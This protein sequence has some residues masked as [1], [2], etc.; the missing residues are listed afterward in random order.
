MT[1]RLSFCVQAATNLSQRDLDV[2]TDG[3][4]RYVKQGFD[5]KNAETMAVADA[6]A[7][8]RAERGELVDALMAQQK[9]LVG[10]VT[11]AELM[12]PSEQ[13]TQ[14]DAKL[15][16]KRMP[17]TVEVS[18]RGESAV[19]KVGSKVVGKAYAWNDS[20][21]DFVIM[22]TE[23][24]EKYRRRG[25]ASAM[26][27]AIEDATG[28]Q[29]TPAVS[30]S[31]DAFEMWKKFRPE[32]VAK[33]LRHWKDQLIGARVEH[34]GNAGKIIKANGGTATMELDK[35][36]ENGGTQSVILRKDLNAAL[37]AGGS[38]TIDALDGEVRQSAKRDGYITSDEIT[39]MYQGGWESLQKDPEYI[40][41]LSAM[42]AA[43]DAASE[44]W[45]EVRQKAKEILLS[46]KAFA[47]VA[48]K[49]EERTILNLASVYMDEADALVPEPKPSI[50]DTQAAMNAYT[51]RYFSDVVGIPEPREFAEQANQER[52][53]YNTPKFK[54]W[55]KDS[56]AVDSN[57][58]PLVAFHVT[59]HDFVEFNINAGGNADKKSHAAYSG[60]LGSWFTAPSLRPESYDIGNAESA[61]DHFIQDADGQSKPGA[62]TM[63]VHLSIQ[64]PMEYDDFESMLEDRDSFPSIAKYKADLVKQGYD[65]IVIRNSDTDG[66]VDRDDWVAF[67]PTQIKSALGNSG[68]FSPTD[69][70]INRS[71]S[72][73]PGFDRF[74]GD[75]PIIELGQKHNF[76]SGEPVVVEVLHGTTNAD[77]TEF[78]RDLAGVDGDW[79]AGFYA[80]NS[81][82]DVALNYANNDAQD[83]TNKIERVA[84]SIE[85]E[86]E[87]SGEFEDQDEIRAEAMRRAKEKITQGSPNTL[88]LFMRLR[89]PVVIGPGGTVLDYDEAYDEEADEYSEPTGKLVEFID[90]LRENASDF[91]MPSGEIETAIADLFADSVD[92]ITVEKAK[93]IL[94]VSMMAAM[95][96]DGNNATAEVIRRSLADIGFDGII[97][98]TVAKKFKMKG[99]DKDSIHFIAFNPNQLKSAT[100]NNG[101]FSEKN[102]ITQ[103]VARP[104]FYSQLQ[105]AIEGVPE[106]LSTQAGAQW[107]LWLDANA[108]KL[109]VTKEDLAQTGIQDWLKQRS[110]QKLAKADLIDQLET[111]GS[112]AEEGASQVDTP[113]FKAWFKD[114]KVVDKSGQPMVVYHGT[115]KSENGEAFTQF[116]TYG[117]NY[118]LMGQGSYFTD[119]A[120]LASSYTKKGRGD[121]PTVYPVYLSIKS[122][123][124]MDARGDEGAWQGA[125][126]DVDFSEYRPEGVKNED[127]YR[128]IEEHLTDQGIPRYEGA[129]IM[130]DG[131]RSMGF[132]GVTHRGGTRYKTAAK[133]SDTRH[134]V[135]I[136]FDPEQIKSAIGNNG[137]FDP[138]NPDITKSVRR[139]LVDTPAFKSW[140]DGS[141]V[142]DENGDPLTVYHTTP[143]DFSEFKAGGDDE[144]KSGR[145]MWFGVD[146][147]NPQAAHNVLQGRRAG[148]FKDGV[149][150]MP[151]YLQMK[152][153]LVIDKSTR[154]WA[155]SVWGSDFPQIMSEETIKDVRQ[156]YDGIIY[157]SPLNGRP[158]E[159]IVFEPNQV[160]SAIGNNGE[161]SPAS[162]DITRSVSRN[163]DLMAGYKLADILDSSKKVSWWD[164]TVGTPYNLAQK[165]P[166]FKRTFDAVQRFISDA[167]KYATRAADLAPNMLP[168]L[169]TMA[170]ITK[171]PVSAEDLDALSGPLF[172]GTLSYTRDE[173]GDPVETSDVGSAGVVWKDSELRSMWGLNDGQ[174]ALYRETRRAINKSISDLAVTDMIRYLGKDVDGVREAALSVGS[175]N[176]AVNILAD[177]L[178]EI[179]GQDTERAE[180]MMAAAEAIREKG[181]AA[182][183]LIARGYA[184]LSRFGDYTVYVTRN[185]GAD[186]VFFGMYETEREANKAARMFREDAE[187]GDAKVEV[188]TMSKEASSLFKG[189]TPE[190]LE[191]FGASLGLEESA[192]SQESQV[193]QAYLK[194]AKNNRSAM[195]RLIERKGVEGFS[196]DSGRVLAN[197][198]YSNARQASTNLNAGEIMKSA[199]DI[200]S[201]DLKD[202]AIKLAQYVQNP[203]EEAAALRGMLFANFIGGSV[204]SALVNL[205]QSFTTT[206]PTLS[207]HFGAV[208]AGKSLTSAMGI[209]K[210]GAGSDADLAKAMRRA[211]E[212]GITAPQEVHH[213]MAQARG[214][215]SLQS[216]DGTR[217]GDILAKINNSFTKLQFIWGRGFGMAEGLNRKLAFVSAYSLARDKGMENPFQFAKDIVDQ[218]Q[219]LMNKGTN[220]AWARGAVGAT[221]F[222]FRKFSIWYLEN[223]TRMW[224]SGK[225]GKQA[226]ALSLAIMF[227]LAGVGGFPFADDLDD[228]VDGFAQ[229]VLN[230][231][232]SSKAEKRD[233]FTSLFGDAGSDFIMSGVTGLP[234]APFDVS[235]RLGMANLIPGTGLLTKKQDHTRDIKEIFGAAGGMAEQAITAAG[236][237]AQGDARGVMLSAV[238]VAVR[239]LLQAKDMADLGM[240]RDQKG[241]KVVDTDAAEAVM[242]AIGFQ[243]ASVKR[244]QESTAMQ[245]S[246][247]GLNK[248]RESEIA[249]LWARGRIERKPELIDDARQQVADW[250]ESNPESKIVIDSS[251]INKRVKQAMMDKAKR[252]E[253]TA[254]KEIRAAVK[255]ELA[256]E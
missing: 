36:A 39:R 60:Q 200:K 59:T 24:R 177:R 186:Q 141:K 38:P 226:V 127:Y 203:A 117:S 5:A 108:P 150:T 145:A 55:F 165:H 221:L 25:I 240:Y 125:F 26:Y 12:Q 219:F 134:Q 92:G 133:E 56:K 68:E 199:N 249:D 147:H 148:K 143:D 162:E 83:L 21:G 241:R 17:Y 218:T 115:N 22:N 8:V 101:D 253:K 78:K 237:A 188:G 163:T 123:I 185:D 144:S 146:G 160:K 243:P 23:V 245:Q 223:L 87:D 154:E 103:S 235:G 183:S 49:Y 170:D 35:P 142:V 119:S 91:N 2:V 171:S 84:E 66:G 70:N 95:D 204:A 139:D 31:D 67:E 93:E 228:V 174:I 224:G 182:Q 27:K 116:D 167:S 96:D 104:E 28:K 229:R 46:N 30:L 211:E 191:L 121:T 220:P 239:N 106:R 242:K 196:E 79:G 42:R 105:R 18:D 82:E 168:K 72:R 195:K 65:G 99:L 153:P 151:V 137:Q 250:N 232:F 201:G 194:L 1:L 14:E 64:N 111:A 230:K 129:E 6:L 54:R 110:K 159:Y 63:L 118:G 157:H 19:A 114:S 132:D 193:F 45:R 50:A 234:G 51:E 44:R 10:G 73:G 135:F 81:P 246:L 192:T 52:S 57:G 120:D 169:D 216:G 161:F 149:R 62:N 252:I 34:R 122:P 217:A 90:A 61:V 86:L 16:A 187:F 247:I 210:N 107:K 156:D 180:A 209:I 100:G 77:L 256:K 181:Q 109:G 184:P 126:P 29:L 80:S 43:E 128:A 238:P 198:V 7:A 112:A 11:R 74:V 97:D 33:D 130:Q 152:R 71:V 244:I 231:S 85:Q 98:K 173:N 48:D 208:R 175:I 47:K 172:Q 255:A 215:A 4:E 88:K 89:N 155:A 13:A 202:Q 227:L 164:K 124:D 248:I 179:A 20:K 9:D 205:T 214:K 58:K 37:K 207:Q 225:E 206:L 94:N 251:Q 15:S 233:F 113:E 75:A 158:S 222:T 197:F 136:A 189:I 40:R 69:A 131:L 138:A 140:F 166:E 178:G 32:A 76:R 190:T 3:I 212:E 41:L 213:L 236:A 254:P 176:G 53:Y 102:D